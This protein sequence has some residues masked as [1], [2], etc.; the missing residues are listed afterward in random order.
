MYNWFILNCFFT[1]ESYIWRMRVFAWAFLVLVLDFAFT[2]L[3]AGW[4]S[5]GGGGGG[6]IHDH[7]SFA[8]PTPGPTQSAATRTNGCNVDS[9]I[10]FDLRTE[11]FRCLSRMEITETRVN[12][13]TIK[14]CEQEKTNTEAN[15]WE[16]I[17]KNK[18]NVYIDGK[19]WKKKLRIN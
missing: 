12:E 4:A 11:F 6:K 14:I 15:I 18:I 17:L 2:E 7:K 1:S 10:A 19:K 9:I 16:D 5:G 3:A 13:Q 8:H